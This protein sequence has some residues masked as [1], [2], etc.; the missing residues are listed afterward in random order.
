MKQDKRVRVEMANG[1]LF[2]F[3]DRVRKIVSTQNLSEW[4]RIEKYQEPGAFNKWMK[5]TMKEVIENIDF[6]IIPSR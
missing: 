5:Q 6:I 1:E 2:I 4:S 3:S